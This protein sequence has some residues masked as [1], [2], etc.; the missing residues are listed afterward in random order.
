MEL[1]DWLVIGLLSAGLVFHVAYCLVPSLR[2]FN[3]RAGAY[4]IGGAAYALIA[5]FPIA[6]ALLGLSTVAF[7]AY[8]VLAIVLLTVIA[9]RPYAFVRAS[10]GSRPRASGSESVTEVAQTQTGR[11]AGDIPGR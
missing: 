7:R 8:L 6:D 5:A 11:Q 2:Y 4:A 1:I 10:G 3:A 9:F